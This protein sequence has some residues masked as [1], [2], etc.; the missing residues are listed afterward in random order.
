MINSLG[1][2]FLS[3]VPICA[4]PGKSFEEENVYQEIQLPAI[5]TILDQPLPFTSSTGMSLW[6]FNY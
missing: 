6:P 1:H 5:T 3:Y 4:A 2:L